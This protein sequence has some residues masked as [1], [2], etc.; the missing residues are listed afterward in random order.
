MD[1][2]FTCGS[3]L[4]F[5]RFLRL[6]CK[7]GQKSSIYEPP[8][9]PR[10][11]NAYQNCALCAQLIESQ[12]IV[13]PAVP[14]SP[15]AFMQ[16]LQKHL[17]QQPRRIAT[18]LRPFAT[19]SSSTGAR[20][21]RKDYLKDYVFPEAWSFQPDHFRCSPIDRCF[22]FLAACSHRRCSRS[23]SVDA[24]TESRSVI[25]APE[26]LRMTRID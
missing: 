24:H 14:R 7:S 6:W 25:C 21:T 26:L 20:P 5:L 15:N 4:S 8:R 17:H 9:T 13:A 16:T 19:S 10:P 2:T 23:F 11:A 1:G 12:M 3:D 18:L 22:H